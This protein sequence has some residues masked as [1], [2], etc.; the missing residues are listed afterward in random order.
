MKKRIAC[1]HA[2]Y[3]NITYIDTSFSTY[4]VEFIHFVD[5]ALLYHM[6]SNEHFTVAEAQMKVKEQIKWVTQ[7]HADA[8]LI[9]CT[10]YIALLQEEVL[11]ISVPIIKVD[12]PYFEAISRIQQPQTILFTNPATVQGT[13]ERLH[14]HADQQQNSLDI[15]ITVINAAFE[16]L[17]KGQQQAYNQAI[18]E[19]VQNIEDRIISVAQLSMVEAAK[20]AEYA[21][22]QSIINPLAPLVDAVVNQLHLEQIASM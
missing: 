12:E 8:I 13:M 16:L 1:L 18:L 22:A 6:T 10:N 15:E 7:C 11:S 3:L 20:Q 14:H 4:D 19:A 9:T 21:T 5:P 17:M 2:H